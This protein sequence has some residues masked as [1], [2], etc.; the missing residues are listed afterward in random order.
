MGQINDMVADIH[1]Y[2]K[3]KGWWENER[4]ALEI[5]MLIVSEIAEATEEVRAGK[6]P[7]Y[8]NIRPASFGEASP[9]I[10]TDPEHPQ[11]DGKPEGEAI[12]LVDAMIRTMD[13]FGKKGWDLE[14]LL[15]MKQA[16]NQKRPYRHGGKLY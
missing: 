7:V 11:S 13:Y 12:E 4:S 3:E 8:F 6:P 16:Y 15:E 5:Q 1:K 2:A 10:T 14:K 9:G